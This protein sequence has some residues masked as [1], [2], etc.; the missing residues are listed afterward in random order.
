MAS[1]HG[2]LDDLKLGN[3]VELECP[4]FAA[5]GNEKVVAKVIEVDVEA[6]YWEFQLFMFGVEF[7]R[8][9]AQ[10]YRGKIDWT[11]LG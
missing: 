2:W 5:L 7:G 11:D 6:Q 3:V 1:K 4:T 10:K 9:G 8:V